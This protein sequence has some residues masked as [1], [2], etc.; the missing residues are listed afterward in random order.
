MT[1]RSLEYVAQIEPDDFVRWVFPHLF[2]SRIP[3]YE[4]IAKQYGYT[5][6]TTDLA[7]VKSEQHFVALI[8][9][10]LQS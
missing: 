1:E 3:R 5:I 10:A 6:S 8:E 9:K 2:Y 7:R 4:A